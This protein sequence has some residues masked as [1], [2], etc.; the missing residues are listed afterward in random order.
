MIIFDE[1]THIPMKTYSSYDTI[2]TM[3]NF[4]IS[5]D[6]N[7]ICALRDSI[8]LIATHTYLSRRV[9]GIYATSMLYLPLRRMLIK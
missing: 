9:I 7:N 8:S 5:R 3:I 1:S 6:N 4:V 2:F